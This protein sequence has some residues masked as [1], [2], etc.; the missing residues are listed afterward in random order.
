[1]RNEP[2]TTVAHEAAALPL[3]LSQFRQLGGEL[4]RCLR[5]IALQLAPGLV[6]TSKLRRRQRHAWGP[7]EPLLNKVTHMER[8]GRLLYEIALPRETICGPGQSSSPSSHQ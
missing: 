8:E 2:K 1:M 3:V 7:L 5:R 4:L 6:D